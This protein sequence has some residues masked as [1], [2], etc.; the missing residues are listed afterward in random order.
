MKS[1]GLLKILLLILIAGMSGNLQALPGSAVNVSKMNGSQ[2]ESYIVVNPTNPQNIVAFSNQQTS[3][4]TF[5]AFT[6]DGG[7]TWTHSDINVGVACCDAQAVTFDSFGNLFLVYING[8]VNQINVI[9]STDGGATFG[10]PITV[11]SGGIDQPSIAAG[12]GSLWVDWNQGGSMRARGAAVTGLGL[13][14]AFGPTQVPPGATGSF[15]GI[16]VGPG[17][18]GSGKVMIV[19]QNPTGGEGPATIS[20]NIDPDGLGPTN[21]GSAIVATTTN[22]GGFDFIPAQSGR[23]VDAES[24][25]AWDGTGGPFNNRVYLVYTQET[26]PENNDTDILVRTSTDDGAT[27]SSPVRVNDDP[28]APIH[29]Q[30]NPSVSMDEKTGTVGVTFHDCRNDNGVIGSGST[31]TIPNDDAMYSAT[32]STDGGATWAPNV[33][34]ACGVS[35]DDA[36]GNGIDYGDYVGTDTYCG[37]VWGAWADN[38]NCTG[39]NPQGTLHQFDLYAMALPFLPINLGINKSDGGASS[40]PGA[41]ITYTLSYNNNGRLSTGVV[42]TDTVPDNTTFSPGDS[43]PGWVCTPDNTAGSSCTLNVAT[44]Q[45]CGG[46]GSATFAVIVDNPLPGGVTQISNT[47]GISDDGANGADSDPSN[48]TSTDTTPVSDQP[49]LTITKSDGD[50]SVAPGGTVVYTLGYANTG[51]LDATGVVISETVPNDSTF[52][53]GSSTG[54]WSCPDGSGAGTTCDLTIGAFAAGAS[55]SAD[56]AVTAVNPVPAGVD[57][58]SN[59]ATISMD[60][61]DPTPGDNTAS[62]TTPLDAAPDYSL[63]KDDG[64]ADVIPGGTAVYT[65]NYSNSGNQDGTGVVLTETVPAGTTFNSAS[66]SP[67]W[68]CIPNNNA[69]SVCTL[70]IGSLTTGSGGSAT[71]AVTANDPVPAGQELISNNASITDDLSNGPDPTPGNN[72]ASDTTPLTAVP[73]LSI[74][75]DDG[76]VTVNPLD[77]VVYTLN[78]SNTGNQNASGVTITETVPVGSAFDSAS[79]TAGWVC[80]PDGNAGSTCTLAVGAVTGN[81]GSGSALFGVIVQDPPGVTELLNTASIADDGTGGPDPTPA[82]NSAGDNTPINVATCLFCD[83][84]EDGIIAP[85]GVWT[86]IKNI[87]PWSETGGT[88]I[89]TTTTRKTSAIATPIF[90]GCLNCAV[91]SAMQ[92]A[93]SGGRASLFAWYVDKK[94]FVEL[95][96]NSSGGKWIFRQRSA[97]KVV[98]KIKVPAVI[99]IGQSYIAHLVF[100]GTNI[101]VTIDGTQILSTPATPVSGT[102]GY[103]VR[104]TTGTFGYIDVR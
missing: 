82:D 89:A 37:V 60:I 25:L 98:H 40:S 74:T 46:A 96:M 24:G 45:G 66:S 48:N 72:S 87:I 12:N 64:G 7:T 8:N 29:S 59:T 1:S 69:G 21:F 90:A 49:D 34:L 18:A 76:N 86:Y 62:D 78:Y 85:S 11:G 26:A 23:S 15:G 42:L 56:F 81:G 2:T 14:G 20:V 84:F 83:D 103:R 51:T 6:T 95:M 88:L 80:V 19:Y 63:T 43:T 93:G 79:S 33:Q 22:V 52:N 97:G 44:L 17:T 27:W 75:K 36:A 38:S 99:N 13:I 58:I 47:A 104:K 94:N 54:T 100:D 91:E 71:F 30:F 101:I 53:A 73:D 57:T 39:D 10:A 3:N 65:L 77:V 32:Y 41:T 31:N 68:S 55:D 16:A 67:G 5:R 70:I 28:A 4:N 92:I 61:P 50:V 9:F 35:N 102:V